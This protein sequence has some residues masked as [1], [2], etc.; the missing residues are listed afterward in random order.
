MHDTADHEMYGKGTLAF[1]SG[2]IRVQKREQLAKFLLEDNGPLEGG[3]V[4]KRFE[5]STPSEME[6]EIVELE[7][8]VPVHI[9][10]MTAWVNDAG[11]VRFEQDIYGRDAK[12]KQ[13]LKRQEGE[14]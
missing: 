12:L 8:P 1:S 9:T 5:L 11:E 6:T 10:Y 14:F 2:C 13:A 3:E 7:T 4:L